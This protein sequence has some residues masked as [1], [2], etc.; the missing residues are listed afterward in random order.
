MVYGTE[1]VS[2]VKDGKWNKLFPEN[3]IS[4]LVKILIL[5]I[6]FQLSNVE[7]ILL[8]IITCKNPSYYLQ[9]ENIWVYENFPPKICFEPFFFT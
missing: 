9:R 7:N 1:T 8:F 6:L 2:T 4:L 5:F 3:I